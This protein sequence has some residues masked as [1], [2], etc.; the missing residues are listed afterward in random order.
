MSNKQLYVN[1]ESSDTILLDPTITDI[2][3]L[4][5]PCDP[6][7]NL[8][9][10]W[11]DGGWVDPPEPEPTFLSLQEQTDYLIQKRDDLLSISDWLV[12]RHEDQLTMLENDPE[13]ISGTALDHDAYLNLLRYRQEL[14][15]MTDGESF[16][17]VVTWT[18]LI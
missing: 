16:P 1:V 18:S 5:V 15:D 7:P 17:F 2:P 13:S 10:L 11:V 4:L 6:K 12:R 9:S 3:P 8:D 14:R